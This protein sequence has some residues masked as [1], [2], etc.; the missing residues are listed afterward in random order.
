[1]ATSEQAITAQTGAEKNVEQE[2]N[3]GGI[4]SR[5]RVYRLLEEIF[6]PSRHAQIQGLLGIRNNTKDAAEKSEPLPAAMENAQMRKR[7]LLLCASIWGEPQHIVDSLGKIYKGTTPAHTATKDAGDE[8]LHAAYQRGRA[9]LQAEIVFAER[10]SAIRAKY[11]D[12]D[13]AW[14]SVRP[15]VPRVVW[16]EAADLTHGLE[17]AY[18]LSKL[19][20][21]A[22]ELSELEPEKAR[23]RFRHF[24]RDLAAL[25]GL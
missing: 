15:L 11:P 24:V 7:I 5:R 12:F 21:L 19:P 2:P 8:A 18:Q 16:E 22:R 3:Y 1:M 4:D 23:E 9:D 10:L 17:A 6:G 13:H 14:A 25:G 20:E